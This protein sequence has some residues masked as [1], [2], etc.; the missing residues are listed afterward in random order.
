MK[1]C[2]LLIATILSAPLYSKEVK[3]ETLKTLETNAKT[4]KHVIK[5]DLKKALADKDL[6]IK[7]F[8]MPLDFESREVTEFLFM[9]YIPTCMHIPP[10]PPNQLILVK[11]AKGKKVKPSFAPVEI[12]GKLSVDNNA[13]LESSFS[14]QATELKEIKDFT[15]ST[16]PPGGHP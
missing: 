7:G 3:W 2:L 13:D 8:M 12:K 14:M 16:L 9:P 5:D 11:M 10:P 6:S 1:L 15:P 4:K